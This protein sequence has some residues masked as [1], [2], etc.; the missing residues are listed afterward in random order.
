MVMAKD[1]Y[2]P[3]YVNDWLSSPIIECMTAE[4]ERGYLRLLCYCWASENASI[5]DNDDVLATLSRMREGWFNGGSHLVRKCFVPH[6]TIDGCLT[7]QR[8][9]DLWLEREE[10]RKKSTEAGKKSGESRRKSSSHKNNGLANQP[11]H[12][13]GTKHEP[14]GNSSSSSSSSI[15]Y[16]RRDDG[17]EK[18]S[19]EEKESE[20]TKVI[21]SDSL[22][23]E[24][25]LIEITPLKPK[26][27][28]ADP[29]HMIQDQ[30]LPDSGF[31][32]EWF[33]RQLGLKRPV[34]HNT[35]ADL[36]FVLC[37]AQYASALTNQTNKSKVFVA[38]V[39]DQQWERAYGYLNRAVTELE[40]LKQKDSENGVRKT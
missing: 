17:R 6:P 21:G 20:R 16:G 8:L 11:S 34:C 22:L 40:K 29:Y 2:M 23:V 30:H 38:M 35:E 4:Q 12:L 1:P 18:K 10:W 26:R 7:N 37:S 31:M 27:L 39:R 13:V 24:A 5:P 32:R 9:Y 14:N 19:L 36:I 28:T 33:Q 25:S 3:F 15:P